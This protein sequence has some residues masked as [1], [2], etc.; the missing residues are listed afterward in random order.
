VTERVEG[1]GNGE[2]YLSRSVDKIVARLPYETGN[3]LYA[4]LQ[5]L[6]AY[7]KFAVEQM[8]ECLESDNPKLKCS[9]AYVLGQ[10]RANEA[11]DVLLSMT[12]DQNR[13][14]RFEVARAVFEIGAWDTIPIII[15][16]L[17]DPELSIRRGCFEVLNRK[18]GESFGYSFDGPEEERFASTRRWFDWWE[19]KNSDQSFTGNLAAR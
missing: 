19:N 7:D 5:L 9:A 10:L 13:Y 12:D 1:P 16:G 3:E 14:V 6:V 4:D 8:L 2:L 18:T 11:L 15:E 17:N